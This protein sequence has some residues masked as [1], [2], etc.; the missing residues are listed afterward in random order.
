MCLKINRATSLQFLARTSNNDVQMAQ[1]NKCPLR[2]QICKVRH[3]LFIVV[4][5]LYNKQTEIRVI[6]ELAYLHY[7]TRFTQVPFVLTKTVYN[8]TYNKQI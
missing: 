3:L 1:K 8:F 7:L 5:N 2:Y 6:L 4:P